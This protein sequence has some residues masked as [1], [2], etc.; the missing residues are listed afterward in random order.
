MSALCGSTCA[1]IAQVEAIE[2]PKTFVV[3]T[4]VSVGI[5]S[6]LTTVD[7]QRQCYTGFAKQ[8]TSMS[9]VEGSAVTAC[10]DWTVLGALLR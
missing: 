5:G 9:C 3:F 4:S 7:V 2:I 6:V 8:S 1:D 10:A